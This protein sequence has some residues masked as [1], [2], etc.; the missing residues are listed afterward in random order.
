MAQS[1]TNI[2]QGQVLQ[3]IPLLAS[4]NPLLFAVYI[5]SKPNT[6]YSLGDYTIRF[7]LMSVIKP[8]SFLYLLE[9]LGEEQVLQ[10]VGTSPSSMAFNSLEQLI[11]D[12]GHPRNPMINSGAITV[13]HKL[14]SIS[15]VSNS[16]NYTGIFLSQSFIEWLN[17]L[18]DTQ[19]YLDVDMLNSVRST[20]SPL[21]LAIARILYENGY[22]ENIESALDIYE[23]IC[24]I[25]GTVMD[26]GKLGKL[27]AHETGLIA[28]QHRL[29]VNHVML[30][31]GLYESSPHYAQ[32]IGL[33]MKSGISGALLTVIPDQGAI[34]IYSPAINLTGNS[35]AGLRF[36]ETLFG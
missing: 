1:Q 8:F 19:L 9:H 3:R 35:I 16:S 2:S 10:S 12:N 22:I 5:Y 31:C 4:I 27:L 13:A 33:P 15:Q 29:L 26:V 7:P 34:A 32:K 21:N 23:E 17:I 6:H 28:P 18:A 30:S 36:I 25:S 20:R 24:C 11:S 14:N